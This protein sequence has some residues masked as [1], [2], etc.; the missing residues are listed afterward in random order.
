MR[1][2]KLFTPLCPHGARQ[3]GLA[4]RK[5]FFPSGCP[6]DGPNM[7]LGRQVGL[8]AD[9][10]KIFAADPCCAELA[11]GYSSASAGSSGASQQSSSS[12]GS[13]QISICTNPAEGFSRTLPSVL[14]MTLSV[15]NSGAKCKCQA[16]PYE[17]VFSSSLGFWEATNLTDTCGNVWSTKATF[18]CGNNCSSGGHP[19]TGWQLAVSTNNGIGFLVNPASGGSICPATSISPFICSYTFLN[20]TCNVVGGGASSDCTCT[21]DGTACTFCAT[22]TI[23][24]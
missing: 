6:T 2:R 17:L 20:W 10:R 1:G 5:I 7:T 9:G 18:L 24:E 14:Y 13:T 16:G 15:I 3:V 11:G 12:S 23:S 8:G 21:G 22:V 19:A 4:E